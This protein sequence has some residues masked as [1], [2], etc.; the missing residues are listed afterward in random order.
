MATLVVT[1]GFDSDA[2]GFVT[3]PVQGGSGVWQWQSFNGNPGGTLIGTGSGSNS[4]GNAVKATTFADLGVPAG[5]VITG[6]SAGSFQARCTQFPPTV[7][8][9]SIGALALT[10]SIG[11]VTLTDVRTI[12]TTGSWFSVSGSGSASGLTLTPADS[13]D[14][15]I[16]YNFNK[17]TDLTDPI[18]LVDNVQF[19]IT[20]TPSLQATMAAT[21]SGAD[22]FAGSGTVPQNFMDATESGPD[23][24]SANGDVIV[25]GS[26]AATE[27]ATK[28]VLAV[29][30]DV[31]LAASL[32]ATESG[33]DTA[34][35]VMQGSISLTITFPF[36]AD[37]DGFVDSLASGRWSWQS[38]GGNPGGRLLGAT[39]GAGSFTGNLARAGTFED[40]GVPAGSTITGFRLGA[41]DAI[42]NAYPSST[43]ALK[44]G[45]LQIGG[46]T[47]VAQVVYSGTTSWTTYT[48]SGV[49]SALSIPSSSA[50]GLQV[51]YELARGTGIGN[52]S[53]SLD[54]VT[55]QIDY[56]LAGPITGQLA[57][58]ETGA[59]A[60]AAD[61]DVAV[62]GTM[63]TQEDGA[64][65][66]SGGAS[67]AVAATM[68]ANEAGADALVAS[69]VVT[70]TGQLA[71]TEAGSDV[72]S[73]TG[74]AEGTIFASMAATETGADVL[75][76]SLT[77]S[78]A[79][80]MAATEGGQD[81]F[82]GMF[83]F[84]VI[85]YGHSLGVG[86][87]EIKPWLYEN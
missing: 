12:T 38:S 52:P 2:Q 22:T 70:I 71:A 78:I 27:A 10:A 33:A 43:T 67:V 69:G 4:N 51:G 54:N 48:Q 11:T 58:T 1:L 13:V 29:N 21:E 68:A 65:V 44:I 55:L 56:Q 66:L 47:L 86:Y 14:V 81:T 73:G 82:A 6:I 53:E 34:I 57:A 37:A 28:D 31:L 8:S 25:T 76:G 35:I 16:A 49:I 60:A 39:S 36:N 42:A 41:F 75:V 46:Q 63:F 18:V 20:Y 77:T 74:G 64:D 15:K 9:I 32:A 24:L 5:A 26:L 7:L 23:V 61:G 3:V 79:G 83:A 62:T 50:A 80:S 87:G 84:E 85:D 17:G 72:F 30:G 59:D 45:P 40:Y 19:T